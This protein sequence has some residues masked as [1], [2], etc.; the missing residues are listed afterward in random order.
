MKP[1]VVVMGV[2]GCGKS[3]LGRLLAEAVHVPFIEGD[4]LHPEE[5]IAKMA[6]GLPLTDEDRVGFLQNVGEA[7]S[8]RTETGIVASCS[9]LKRAYRDQLRRHEGALVFVF[10]VIGED[11][12]RARLRARQDHFMPADLLQ[13]QLS[14]LEVPEKD[15]RAV[16]VD[17]LLPPEKQVEL[18]MQRLQ[19]LVTT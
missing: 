18:V 6:S 14:I 10:A 2:S 3:T 9:A 8:S 11:A 13:S 12:L 17:G 1:V 7:I 15:E 16:F 4:E 5:N 19:K